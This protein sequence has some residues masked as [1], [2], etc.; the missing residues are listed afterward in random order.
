MNIFLNMP[1]I[2]HDCLADA[3]KRVFAWI[4]SVFGWL[5]CVCV[6]ASGIHKIIFVH[7]YWNKINV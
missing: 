4:R 1:P 2:I 3:I 6:L 7:A 5:V